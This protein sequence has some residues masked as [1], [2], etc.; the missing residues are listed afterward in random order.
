MNRREAITLLGGAATWPVVGHAQQQPAVPVIGVLSGRSLEDSKEF[1]AAF[2][3]GLNEAG[4]FRASKC[5][6]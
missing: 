2:G 5:G 6:D 3:Q 4:L 1:V